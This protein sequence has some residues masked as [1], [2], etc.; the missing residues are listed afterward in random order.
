MSAAAQNQ[1]KRGTRVVVTG[2]LPGVPEG[3]PGTAGR[4]VGITWARSRV[5][6]DN[7]VEVGAVGLADLVLEHDWPQFQIDRDKRI[8]EEAAK[9]KAAEAADGESS[10]D[11][12]GGN[13]R[14]A[15]LMA[16]SKSARGAKS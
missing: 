6:F 2:D 15:A 7:G 9:A 16:R 14:L 3:T 5:E 8:A 13:D 11:D 4:P 12:G 10:G 1:I